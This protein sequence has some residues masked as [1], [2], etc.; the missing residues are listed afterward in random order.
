MAF[1]ADMFFTW[2]VVT[3][4]SPSSFAVWTKPSSACPRR[5]GAAFFRTGA[6]VA[7][8]GAPW[9]CS[10]IDAGASRAAATAR[11]STLRTGI[12]QLLEKLV[13]LGG[14]IDIYISPFQSS[15]SG[16]IERMISRCHLPPPQG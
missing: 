6:G 8:A 15:G 11:A 14:I 2:K 1:V 13:G 5:V 10:D 16:L 12:V 7:A 3:I 9:A 4:V